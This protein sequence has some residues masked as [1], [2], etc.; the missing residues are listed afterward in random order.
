MTKSFLCSIFIATGLI[1]GG[2]ITLLRCLLGVF[3]VQVPFATNM[4]LPFIVLA[5]ISV[6]I[7]GIIIIY[8]ILHEKRII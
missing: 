8:A 7:G 2:S 3:G 4:S 5:V 1:V 6:V